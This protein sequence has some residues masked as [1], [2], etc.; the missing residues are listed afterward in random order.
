MWPYYKGVLIHLDFDILPYLCCK[1][2]SFNAEDASCP[3]SES[4]LCFCP[5]LARAVV[6][7]GQQE[8]AVL[9]LRG[10]PT[11]SSFPSDVTA[12][13]SPGLAPVTKFS[14]MAAL[15]CA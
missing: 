7:G 3:A 9:F 8:Q 15:C 13:L 4:R 6:L 5:S 2:L 12:Q 14:D 11:G 10:N 1:T